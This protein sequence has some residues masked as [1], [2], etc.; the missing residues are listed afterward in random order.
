MKQILTIPEHSD[1]LITEQL[2][3]NLTNKKAN[4]NVMTVDEEMNR[5][6]KNVAVDI[7]TILTEQGYTEAEINTFKTILKSFVAKA[8]GV[9]ASEITGDIF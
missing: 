1:E 8:W 3:I 9:S 2:M 6:I 7:P 4:V 5:T